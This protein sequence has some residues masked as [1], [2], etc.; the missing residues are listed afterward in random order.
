[1]SQNDSR[2]CFAK[3]QR[4]TKSKT[5]VQHKV[6][7]LTI[8][9]VVRQNKDQSTALISNKLNILLT[10]VSSIHGNCPEDSWCRWRQTSSSSK[11]PPAAPINYSQNEIDKIKVVFD[12]EWEIL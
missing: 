2:K 8:Q 12:Y 5:Y 6:S 9:Q 4:N 1:M 10:H 11:P 7:E 3:K